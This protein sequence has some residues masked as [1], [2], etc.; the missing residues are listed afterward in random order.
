MTGK[1]PEC[2]KAPSG[3]HIEDN[4][5]MCYWD[6]GAVLNTDS[7]RAYFGEDPKVTTEAPDV[8]VE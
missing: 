3:Y 6:C 8:E 1:K 7:Y 2:P 4:Q 5:G